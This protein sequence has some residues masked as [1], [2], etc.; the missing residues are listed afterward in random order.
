VLQT[1]D[2]R[3]PE[4]PGHAFRILRSYQPGEKV[5]LGVLRQRKSLTLEATLP[6]PDSLGEGAPHRRPPMPP[7]SPSQASASA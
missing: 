4:N 7:P 5:K 3:T 1:I 6:A 2:G